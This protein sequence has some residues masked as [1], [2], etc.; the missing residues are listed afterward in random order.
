[1]CLAQFNNG[2]AVRTSNGLRMET[3][4][5]WICVFGAAMNTPGENSQGGIVAVVGNILYERETRS[6]MRAVN[7]RI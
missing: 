6:A 3:P 4:V 2:A 5:Q 7:E 1:M